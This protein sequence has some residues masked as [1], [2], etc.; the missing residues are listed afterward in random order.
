MAFI[1]KLL[2]ARFQV[3]ISVCMNQ[4]HGYLKNKKIIW[5]CLQCKYARKN[6]DKEAWIFGCRVQRAKA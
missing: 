5:S 3:K 4:L 2:R 1:L 6:D